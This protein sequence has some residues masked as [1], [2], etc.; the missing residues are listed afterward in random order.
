[1]IHHFA[2]VMTEKISPKLMA[3]GFAAGAAAASLAAA[4]VVHKAWF[5]E[6]NLTAD[7]KL[8]D[9]MK[10]LHTTGYKA[11][12]GFTMLGPVAIGMTVTGILAKDPRVGSV[13]LGAAG[14]ILGPGWWGTMSLADNDFVA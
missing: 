11:L 13:L 10:F 4:P 1:M 3:V 7:T 6:G 8:P 2:A 5:G 12:A 14:G 9:G